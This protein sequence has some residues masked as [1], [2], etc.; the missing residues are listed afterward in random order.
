MS[1]TQITLPEKTWVQITTSDKSGSI[2]HQSGNTTIVYT[3]S[4][5]EPATLNP[6]TPV[7]EST[8]KDQDWTYFNV[9]VAD[10]VWAWANS[11]DAIVTVSPG[12]A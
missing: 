6:N 4:S 5:T 1:S 11:S 10:F 3:E 7:M 2:R 12:S 9:A 8:I